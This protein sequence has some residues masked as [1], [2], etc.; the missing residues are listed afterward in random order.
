[1]RALVV[2]LISLAGCS[3]SAP[4]TIASA[5]V[6]T[7]LAAGFAATERAGG[8]CY[9]VCTHRTVCN[10]RSGFCEPA[11]RVID[12]VPALAVCIPGEPCKKP[13]GEPAIAKTRPL[14][15]RQPNEIL[16]G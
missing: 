3:S 1:M 6:H 11:D 16:P 13:S 5:A 2:T 14:G 4:H 12:P 8:R 10:P 7:G 9:A 15:V